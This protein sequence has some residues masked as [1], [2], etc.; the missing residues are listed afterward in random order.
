MATRNEKPSV[1][2]DAAAAEI[3][4]VV[5]EAEERGFLGVE[6][7]QTPNENYTVAGV[8][9]GKPTPET[10]P[11]HARKIRQQLDDDARSR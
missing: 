10:N 1:P 2:A 3:Q 4:K 6:V 5:D 11:E 7:D 9:A 8:L